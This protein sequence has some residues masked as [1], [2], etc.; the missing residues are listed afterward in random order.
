VCD[1]YVYYF[2]TKRGRNKKTKQHRDSPVE[3]L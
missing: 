2:V 3:V 1:T